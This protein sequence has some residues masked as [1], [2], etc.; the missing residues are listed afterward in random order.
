MA[1]IVELLAL[2]GSVIPN[3]EALI[4]L[5]IALQGLDIPS[6]SIPVPM[7]QTSHISP[8]VKRVNGSLV[9]PSD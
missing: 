9:A 7:S 8:T 4:P 5:P 1:L 3:L 6:E 2:F